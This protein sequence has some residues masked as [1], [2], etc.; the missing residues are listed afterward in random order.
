VP[1][2]PR[3]D[4]CHVLRP[5]ALVVVLLVVLTGCGAFTAPKPTA[6]DFTDIVASLVRR[7]MTV[8]TQVGGDSGC[9]TTDASLHSN[10][11][12]YDVRPAGDTTSYPV[13]VFGWKSQATY[14]DAKAAFDACANAGRGTSGSPVDTVEHLPWR[15]Y[16]IGWPP[17]LRDAVDVALTEAGGIPAPVQPE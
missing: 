11:V 14:D 6:G 3:H 4:N 1:K 12:R 7:N 8:T 10:A 13:Y 2:R 17:A 15:A 9:A 16:G 5:V